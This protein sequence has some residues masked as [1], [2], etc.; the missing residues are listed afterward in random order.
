M[1]LNIFSNRSFRDITQ[2]PV[3]P[4]LLQFYDLNNKTLEKTPKKHETSDISKPL[5]VYIP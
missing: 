4:W 2:Y 5:R 3:F 1:W